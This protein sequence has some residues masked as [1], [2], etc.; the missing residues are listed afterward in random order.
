MSLDYSLCLINLALYEAN[1]FCK[2][3]RRFK[4]EFYFPILTLN[5]HVHPR[6][7]PRKEVEAKAAL[8]ENCWAHDQN[9][10]R[11]RHGKPNRRHKALC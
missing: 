3:N 6:F 10:T 11:S 9:H 8:A 7:F 5:M 1:G 2:F 4:P